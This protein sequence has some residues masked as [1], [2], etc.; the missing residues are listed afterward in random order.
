MKK[1]KVIR[2]ING[3]QQFTEITDLTYEQAIKEAT[4]ANKAKEPNT[5]YLA[6]PQ[7]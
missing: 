1:Y 5:K 2:V 3:R 7:S 4:R 6:V